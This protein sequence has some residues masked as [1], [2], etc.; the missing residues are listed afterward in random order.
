M[1]THR[2]LSARYLLLNGL[3]I[4]AM[5][6][7][8]LAPA[9]AGL[10]AGITAAN[11]E[12]TYRTL[13]TLHHAYD[14]DRLQDLGLTLYPVDATQRLVFATEPQL[15]TLARRGYEP[16]GI[17]SEDTLE[18]LVAD[19][20]VSGSDADLLM[21]NLEAPDLDQDGVSD[22]EEAWWCTNPNDNNSDSPLP[23]SV[24][25]PSD[26][27]EVAAILDGIRAYGPP[28]QLWP[29]FTP[30][31]PAGDCPDGDFDGVPDYAEEFIIG[32]SQL[33]ES[34]DKDKFDDGQEL[35]GIT[36]CPGTGGTCSYGLL[37]RA[38]DSAWISANLPAWVLPP[39][40]SPWVAAFPFP[41]VDVVP[42]SL[43]MTAVTV[44]TTDHTITEGE[45]HTYGTATTNG[46]S[47]SLA[48]TETWNEWIEVSK[49]TATGQ[50]SP[51]LNP[52]FNSSEAGNSEIS[53]Q[54]IKLTGGTV[55][56]LGGGAAIACA[57]TFLICGPTLAAAIAIPLFFGGVAGVAAGLIAIGE[58]TDHG[59]APTTT[60]IADPNQGGATC[61]L[62]SIACPD[63]NLELIDDQKLVEIT[64]VS[65][66]KQERAIENAGTRYYVDGN[67][68]LISQPVY[69]GSY[70]TTYVPT[71]T[72]SH[73]SE[74]GGAQTTTST[75]YE[76][77]T[78]SEASTNQFS[79]SWS[80]ATAVD[81]AHA[82][83]LR[84][85]YDIVNTGTDYALEV[86]S[87]LFNVYIGSDPNP[88]ATYNALGSLGTIQNLFPG[89]ALTITSDPI[90]LTLDQMRAIDEGAPMR[91]VM[92]DI[93]FGQDEVF[94]QDALNSSVLVAM[95]DGFNDGDEV[96]DTYL[97]AVWDP[98]DT[99]QDVLKRYFP[100]T[101]DVDGNLLSLSTP[102]F[103]TNPATFNTHALNG[104][105]WWNL[106]LSDELDYTG[107]FKNT[108]AV[109]NSTVLVRILSDRDLDGYNDRNETRLGT[110][111]DDPA[112]HPDPELLAGY[113]TECVGDDCS[114]LMTFLNNGNYDAYGVEAVM[115]TPDGLTDITNNTIGGS[116][117]VPAGAQVVLG[118]RILQP[119]LTG[120][121][122][123]ALPYSSGFYLGDTDRTYTLTAQTAGSIGQVSPLTFD[124]TDGTTSG[125]VNFGS[126]YDAPLPAPVNLGVAI[127]FQT[128]AVNP[129]ETFTVQALTPRD[130]FQYTKNSPTA[131]E[132]VIVVSYNDP[133]G[134]HRFILPA[135]AS[136][137]NHDNLGADLNFL[138]GQML[139]DPGVDV[140]ST[141]ANEAN[142]IINAPH[143]EAI[144]D[145]HL[146]VEYID[147]AGNVD[148]ED[149]YTMTLATG[150]TVIPVTISNTFMISPT[151]YII[152]A[153]WTDSQGN[154]IDSSAR[155]LASFGP[156][157]LPQ[158]ALSTTGWLIGTP[159]SNEGPINPWN[160]GAV[161]AGTLLHADLVLA[162]TG[163]ASLRYALTGMGSELAVS[164]LAAGSLS[165]ADA[166]VFNLTLD[167]AGLPTGSYTAT[168]TMRTSD[169]TA[170]AFTV[171]VTG[172]IS[173]AT[174]DA[175]AYQVSAYRP[176][177]QYV[178]VEGPKTLNQVITFTHTISDTA[179]R[180]HPMYLY[181][182]DGQTLVGT[183]E[184][185]PDFTGQTAPFGV[186]GDGSDGDLIVSSGQTIY[187]DD[188]RT[189]LSNSASAG[190]NT[191]CVASPSGFQIG[192]EVL[193]IQMQGTG[194]PDYEFKHITDINTCWLT[195]DENLEFTYTTPNSAA[196]VLRVPQYQNVTVQNGGILTANAW[197]GTTGWIIALRVS[198]TLTVEAGGV[199]DMS[200]RG[201]RGGLGGTKSNSQC[202]GW[203]GESYPG[204]SWQTPG[205]NNK[206]PVNGGGGGGGLGQCGGG[207]GGGGGGGGYGSPGLKYV[208]NQGSA[209][210][211]PGGAYGLG[212]LSQIF[213]GSGGGG[214]GSAPG[215]SGAQGGTGGAG[216]GAIIIF[217]RIINSSGSIVSNGQNGGNAFHIPTYE[218]GGGGGGSGGSI[219]LVGQ[220]VIIGSSVS[221]TG[222]GPGQ[223]SLNGDNF[224]EWGGYGGDGRIHIEYGSISGSTTPVA[225]TQQ[226]NFYLLRQLFGPSNI[227]E[228]IM[229]DALN[230][231]ASIRYS[232]QYGQRSINTSGGA[233]FYS[234]RVPN[235][236]YASV[237]LS[238][239]FHKVAGSASTINFCLDFGANGSC[240]WTPAQ[241]SFSGPIQLDTSAADEAA[242][243]NALNAYI[244]SQP[245]APDYL[246]PISVTV[247]T[248]ADIF[249]FNLIATPGTDVDLEPTS[250]TI[251]PPGTVAPDNI[252]EGTLVNLEAEIT[253]NGSHEAENFVVAFFNGDPINGGS[254]IGSTFI[255]SLLPGT[256]SPPQTVAWN[257]TALLGPQ[258]IYVV[259]DGPEIVSESDE[260]NN[261]ATAA[262]IV[263]KKADLTPLSLSVPEVRAGE[264][265]TVTA[266]IS[267][268][269]EADVLGIP[270]TL[271]E[272]FPL[273]GTLAATDIISVTAFSTTTAQFL[274]TP[275]SAG[276]HPLSVY[277][278][279]ADTENEDDETNNGLTTSVTVGW[280][281][282]TVDAGGPGDTAYNTTQGYGWLTAG[283][284][285]NS[286]G[287]APYQT[288][289]Q[290]VSGN[291]L[292][293]QF[294]NLLPGRFYHLDLTFYLCSGSRT[295]KVLVDNVEVA[296]NITA[297]SG[298]QVTI[299][300]LLDPSLY[301]NDG[302]VQVAIVKDSGGLGG[303]VVSVIDLT[304]VRYCYRDSGAPGE[305]GYASAADGC[306]WLDGTA[307]TSWGTL[308]SESVRYDEGSSVQYQFDQLTPGKDYQIALTLFEAD[309]PGGRMESVLIDGAPVL[310]NILLNGTAQTF[311]I[312]VPTN[313]YADGSILVEIVDTS[314]N[315]QPVVSE[316][317]VEEKTVPTGGGTP[318]PTPTPTATGTAT[319]TVTASA[320]AT[321]TASATA[322]ATFTPL[323]PTVTATNT[324]TET[325]GPSP[326]STATPTATNTALP[327]T[328]TP[329]PTATPSG[330][331]LIFADSFESGNLSAW[332]SSFT[333][334]GDL[335]VT[336]SA[337]MA[338]TSL[339]LQAQIDDGTA[340][341]VRDDTPASETRYRARFYF[342]P[343]SIVMVDTQ[344]NTLFAAYNAS[345][346]VVFTVEIL[347]K[348]SGYFIRITT[349]NDASTN[350][351]IPTNGI[352][353]SNSAHYIEAYWGAATAGQNNGFAYLYLDGTQVAL[354]TALDND[355]KSIEYVRLG[356]ESGLDSGTLGTLYFDE[357][358]S[359]RNSPIG[360]AASI[361]GPQLSISE[362]IA[363]GPGQYVSVPVGLNTDG[364]SVGS[365][366]FTLE[367][368]Q[369]WLLFDPTDSDGDGIPDDITLVMPGIQ[370]AA[371]SFDDN[372]SPA[373]LEFVISSI[374][375]PFSHAASEELL[376]VRFQAAS[377]TN[378][379]N[380]VVAF[381]TNP[382]VSFYDPQG[383]SIPG[384]AEDGSVLISVGSTVYLPLVVRETST[385]ASE[386]G[387]VAS[388]WPVS[389]GL[390]AVWMVAFSFGTH[391]KYRR[392]SNRQK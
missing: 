340:L 44:I 73:G 236:H 260:A 311:V 303:P 214:G 385:A 328:A 175:T 388:A 87:L 135:A 313:T 123:S 290:E 264:Q 280:D 202:N 10:A 14:P 384:S 4:F 54:A 17:V 180:M 298:G 226:V 379:L 250:L 225:N 109:A 261:T 124:W 306:G 61:T 185:G 25:N 371:V 370:A 367:F 74:H 133:Q 387:G 327:P 158:A 345:G 59:P 28:F 136:L 259:V 174:G 274:W 8:S 335:T 187:T 5:A 23:P 193:I 355:T 241:Q 307:D 278:D 203:N 352:S 36:F 282:L 99:V 228:L 360:P 262:A 210:A 381:S 148:Q 37:P 31:N 171:N 75:E 235:R 199:I 347:K 247:D 270:I 362:N 85:T 35:F 39:G 217:G 94:Y 3:V 82:A 172:T 358:V 70:P 284:V 212:D 122:G 170:A 292:K 320:T 333:D 140:A 198:G 114:V 101:E 110:D 192:D 165:P 184:F 16:A 155:P 289:R 178:Y 285:V 48:N 168:L 24:T 365:L 154:I 291:Q 41:E 326:T 19:M 343:N 58:A 55:A 295:M 359:H 281:E 350:I 162:N 346:S 164:G 213:L 221:A 161:Q 293:Y 12:K 196:Q 237:E 138:S 368:D 317:S 78:I 205:D 79:E 146:F 181:S 111:P 296:S 129:G 256:T 92:E 233:Q 287:A 369:D 207:Q 191:I 310:S 197:N 97:I 216:G 179:E 348:T 76:E 329:T 118:N 386:T 90:A 248:S 272:G 321:A 72:T 125:T 305:V 89:D 51:S 68:H 373:R 349:I 160:F 209:A 53:G 62:E 238:A 42:S 276:A 266:V 338:L 56:V 182:E 108:L 176:W 57:F 390:F 107:D 157:P 265:V 231:G 2:K 81:T 134:N 183:G 249:L 186:F 142:F 130:T 113:T 277:S 364:P 152:L 34:S 269:G 361:T 243:A 22:Q 319:P 244:Q 71:T 190:Q 339:G 255:E 308:P 6:F 374:N 116:G 115:Y 334:S 151:E 302:Q 318:T 392:G 239:L 286:C 245:P 354:S 275:A 325:P 102:E 46:T 104:T 336:G 222:G 13:V 376:E 283:T 257:T 301:T 224:Q 324:A 120:W 252:A 294:D 21:L 166:R 91:V 337:A 242:L 314:P 230:S 95:E 375:P 11:P 43:N 378:G 223:G 147:S 137:G 64:D 167:T 297:S 342:N 220:Q 315:N 246:V 33:R 1:N 218:E 153:F 271:Y 322:T 229:P 201:F 194:S 49:T 299:S 353:L 215:N 240:D 144:T 27:D 127:G 169:P 344:A 112:D 366:T 173:P 132:P 106:Y 126:G 279:P 380:T 20:A 15:A 163:L 204:P 9:A 18:R 323:P 45:E 105:S 195:L 206:T 177:D 86:S 268:S 32:T 189:Q 143:T 332:S 52:T 267:N 103:T 77:Q 288:Y 131:L 128:G 258:T 88:I 66:N 253:N 331:D 382:P 83:D 208:P 141:A 139:P 312:D 47:T 117:R 98:S 316:I 149:V 391:R 273:T 100:V 29:Q 159:V 69:S 80:T 7:N 63:K 309:N 145:A 254:L 300:L 60:I 357:F 351:R 251:D 30:Y 219:K 50:N 232:T 96:I 93:A 389:A 304:E 200:A 188:I 65:A 121:S 26:G 263:R 356:P 40:D 372:T 119:D 150:P 67:G 156:D 234:V 383:L 211:D 377:S 341:Y 38:E 330:G 227:T 363:A 84:F